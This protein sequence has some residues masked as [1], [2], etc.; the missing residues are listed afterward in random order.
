MPTSAADL[1]MAAKASGVSDERVLAAIAATPRAAF[2]PPGY[3]AYSDQPVPI[4]HGLV[5]TQPSLV[6]AMV[7]GLGLTGGEHVLEIGAG[8]GYQT[9]LLARLAAHVVSVEIW[10]DIAAVAR[11]NLARQG[12]VNVEVVTGDGTEGHAPGAPYDAILVS[13]AHPEVSPPLIAQLRDGGRLVQPIGPGGEEDVVLFERGPNG[14]RRLRVLTA[15]SF[16]RLRGRY[17]FPDPLTAG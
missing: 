12:I 5:T 13:A 11:R 6:A 17:G 1:V 14:L 7:A 8:F 16:V 15:A 3:A 2:T 9:A 4:P 10:P